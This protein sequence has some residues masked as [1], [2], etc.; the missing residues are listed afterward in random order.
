MLDDHDLR[1]EHGGAEPSYRYIA[2]D[3]PEQFMRLGQRFLG[4]LGSTIERVETL[5]LG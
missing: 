4:E 5:T 1:A 2:S 3:A